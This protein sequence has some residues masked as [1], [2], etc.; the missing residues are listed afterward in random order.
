MEFLAELLME[1][2]EFVV[3]GTLHDQAAQLTHLGLQER[4]DDCH[5]SLNRLIVHLN[6][7]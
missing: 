1:L 3:C 7:R 2:L 5:V 6:Q 4:L